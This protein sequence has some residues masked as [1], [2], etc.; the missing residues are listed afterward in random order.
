MKKIAFN[1]S[2]FLK[3]INITNIY[4]FDANCLIQHDIYITGM[5]KKHLQFYYRVCDILIS[6]FCFVN[7][8]LI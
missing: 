8:Y 5:Y 1:V 4:K 6:L 2:F 3:I 7:L